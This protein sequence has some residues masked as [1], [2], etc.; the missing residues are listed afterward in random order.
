MRHAFSLVLA[1]ALC[2]LLACP[3][4]QKPGGAP[5]AKKGGT[6]L[7]KVGSTVI[8]VEEFEEKLNQQ[9]PFIRSRYADVE[10]RREYLD[11]QVRFELLAQ[12]ALRRGLDKDPEIQDSLKKIIV[13]KLTRDEFDNRVKLEDISNA[14]AETYYQQHPDEYHKPEMVR[15]AHIFVPFGDDQ[16]AAKQQADKVRKELRDKKQDQMAFRTLAKQY[17]A[18]AATK[19]NG[20]DLRYM[21]QAEF[22]QEYGKAFADAAFALK[23]LNDQS[24][25][26]S[27][28]AGFHLLQQT[29]RRPAIDRT[30][31]QVKTQ[32]K[33]RLYRDKRT[34]A[35]NKFIED[36]KAK[37]GV[38]IDEQQLAAVKILGTPQAVPGGLPPPGPLTPPGAQ[39]QAGVDQAPAPPPTK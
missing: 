22:E 7:A 5:A 3:A 35:F 27:G 11:N 15:V 23:N 24:D 6:T 16:A 4:Q 39:Q 36:L 26:V 37:A 33:N 29:G 12:E 38:S 10:K 32:I 18:D 17:S 19:D 8:T 1:V 28:K 20:G 9:S 2:T 14:E 30:L 25:V 21:T 34:E 13:Q 31:D